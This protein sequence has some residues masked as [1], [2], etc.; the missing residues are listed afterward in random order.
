MNIKAQRWCAWSIVPFVI[1]YIIGFVMI[2]R[3][4]PPTS[5]M[6]EGADLVAFYDNNRLGIQIGQL[7]G[8]VASAFVLVWPGA[9]SA[10]M[11]RIE[12]GPLPML[13][14]MQYGAATVLA[15]LFMLCSLIWS[16]AAYRPDISA[17]NLRLLHDSGWLI[18]V[19][20]YPEY[21]VQLGCIGIV[22]LADRRAQ[23]FLPRWACYITFLTAFTGI[24]GGFSTFVKSG[25]FAWDGLIGFWVPVVVFLA[26]MVL[27]MLPCLLKAIAREAAEAGEAA[28]SAQPRG[29]AALAVGS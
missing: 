4:V 14:L 22:G 17:D 19:M 12:K 27:V 24:G 9:I 15:M 26:W 20:A 1:T 25:P 29:Q 13:S 10:Q 23:P 18:F 28:G 7:I 6:I 16:I 8:L 21:I 11:A 3:F 2:A 5:P